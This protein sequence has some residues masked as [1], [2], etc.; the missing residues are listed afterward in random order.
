MRSTR[1]AIGSWLVLGALVVFLPWP[2]VG[3]APAEKDFYSSQS[4]DTGGNHSLW[5]G[6]RYGRGGRDPELSKLLSAESSAEREVNG[7]VAEYSRKEDDKERAKVKEKLSAA[8][9]KQFDLQQ[10]RR[11]HELAK[12]EAQVKKLRELMKKRGEERKAIIDRRL[13]QL[14]REAEGLGWTPPPGLRSS[15]SYLR[16]EP[17][18][19]PKK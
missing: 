19:Q 8:L 17:G 18:A 7:L 1:L 11:E 6:N 14:M 16:S 2:A 10:K 15:D 12:V 5:Y 4:L 9:S 3:Q 13:D